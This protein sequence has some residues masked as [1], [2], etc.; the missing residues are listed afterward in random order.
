MGLFAGYYR[1]KTGS[2][3]PAILI[4]ISANIGGYLAGFL[5]N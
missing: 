3:I 4:H 1:E 5:T 2:L